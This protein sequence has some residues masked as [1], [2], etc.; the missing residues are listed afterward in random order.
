MS[1]TNAGVQLLH[2]IFQNR[3]EQTQ[4]M[5]RAVLIDMREFN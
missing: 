2:R 5:L 4:F 3:N 1:T